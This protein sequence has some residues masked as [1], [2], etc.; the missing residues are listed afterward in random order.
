MFCVKLVKELVKAQTSSREP[1]I[2]EE[3]CFLHSRGFESLSNKQVFSLIHHIS[4]F[5]RFTSANRSLL[6]LA[7]MSCNW[8]S[9]TR[10]WS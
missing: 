9:R 4:Q 6:A 10:S 5:D 7:S 2:S 8:G 1:F 3:L